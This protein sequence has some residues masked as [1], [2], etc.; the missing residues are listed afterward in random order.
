[1][2]CLNLHASKCG[3]FYIYNITPGSYPRVL[4]LARGPDPKVITPG[5]P[6]G[7]GVWVGP[8]VEPMTTSI[9]DSSLH[10]LHKL[11]YCTFCSLIFFKE[12]A[13]PNVCELH[14]SASN[15][16]YN[17]MGTTLYPLQLQRERK[18]PPHRTAH[19]RRRFSACSS[20]SSPQI[21]RYQPASAC[22]WRSCD[23]LLWWTRSQAP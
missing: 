10:N 16:I 19:N 18:F 22:A 11:H 1:M 21:H 23:P 5:L 20:L 8:L 3:I 15:S 2:T 14:P 13:Q 7:N 6:R 4:G 17:R 9:Q 12:L